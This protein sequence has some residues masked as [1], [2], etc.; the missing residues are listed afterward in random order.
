MADLATWLGAVGG[1]VGALGGP[2][3]LW[4]AYQQREQVRREAQR[5]E[6]LCRAPSPDVLRDL[7]V[8]KSE[9]RALRETY[10]GR[11]WWDASPARDAARRLR[12]AEPTLEVNEGVHGAVVL[13]VAHFDHASLMVAERNHDEHQRMSRVAGQRDVVKDLDAALDRAIRLVQG[14]I[15][16]AQA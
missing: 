7:L 1:A 8:V 15:H 14:A 16:A 4:A 11:T 10:R 9:V 2:A 12:D 13:V 6:A 3:G 5:R